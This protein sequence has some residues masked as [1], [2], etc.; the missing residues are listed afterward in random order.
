MRDCLLLGDRL[1][2]VVVRDC[3][4]FCRTADHPGEECH[5]DPHPEDH[6]Q[7]LQGPGFGEFNDSPTYLLA[8]D[9]DRHDEDEPPK[10]LAVQPEPTSMR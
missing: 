10:A 9:K 8:E 4:G 1:W 7:Q 2:F 5:D 3:G 6:F